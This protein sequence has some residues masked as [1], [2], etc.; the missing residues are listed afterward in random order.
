MV[1]NMV[2]MMGREGPTEKVTFE[3]R[4]SGSKGRRQE[5]SWGENILD[6]EK[7]RYKGPE[8]RAC[9][10]CWRHIRKIGIE[11]QRVGGRW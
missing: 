5:N 7:G 8:A 9:P 10:V 1:V 4:L 6:R 2:D 3:E 11:E